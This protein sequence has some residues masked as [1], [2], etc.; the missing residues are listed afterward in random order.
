MCKAADEF[1]Q[2]RPPAFRFVADTNSFFC[3]T[4]A[5]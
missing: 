5:E 3:Y 2:R 1:R 4:A